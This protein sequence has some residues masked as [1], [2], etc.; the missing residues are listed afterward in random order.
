MNNEYFADLWENHK[1]AELQEF[2]TKPWLHDL[3]SNDF[4]KMAD[5]LVKKIL[6]YQIPKVVEFSYRVH[7][8]PRDFF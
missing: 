8:N 5:P 3:E 1:M 4:F 7:C 6:D 2:H